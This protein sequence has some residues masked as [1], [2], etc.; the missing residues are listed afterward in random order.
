MK[1]PSS[2]CAGLVVTQSSKVDD[3]QWPEDLR[4]WLTEERLVSLIL[5]TVSSLPEFG[6]GVPRAIHEGDDVYSG[7]S[8]LTLLAYAYLTA[9]C[10]SEHLESECRH[11]PILAYLS[12]RRCPSWHS[13]R[14]FRRANRRALQTC[15][16]IVLLR[17]WQESRPG[18]EPSRFGS[19]ARL[20][21]ILPGPEFLLD[22][23]AK[24]ARGRLDV[25]VQ[26]DSMALDL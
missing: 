10:G 20:S 18:R 19:S 4:A 15:L 13:L 26:I 12:S 14:K 5:D 3:V 17:A 25:A 23:C 6:L 11:D 16:E 22:L 21:A 7:P 9:R 1:N 2:A 8:L 24:S